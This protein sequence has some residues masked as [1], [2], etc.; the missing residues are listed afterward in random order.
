MRI[1][2]QNGKRIKVSL[3]EWAESMHPE[4]TIH[5]SINEKW[6]GTFDWVHFCKTGEVVPICCMTGN[7]ITDG[8]YRYPTDDN[9]MFIPPSDEKVCEHCRKI[10]VYG[11]KRLCDK[12]NGRRIRKRKR[13]YA[14]KWRKKHKNKGKT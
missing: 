9:F 3:G 8:N 6:D 11:K 12:C 10:L 14:R 13:E 1:F 7:Q 4:F 5:P 2:E